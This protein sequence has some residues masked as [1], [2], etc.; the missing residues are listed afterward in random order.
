MAC[1]DLANFW[2]DDL[3][4]KMPRG[5]PGGGL[6][7][8]GTGPS[9]AGRGGQGLVSTLEPPS[10]RAGSTRSPT[11]CCGQRPHG[12]ASFNDTQFTRAEGFRP[13]AGGGRASR[14]AS[15]L[16]AA[17]WRRTPP[18]TPKGPPH[19]AQPDAVLRSQQAALEL[20]WADDLPE[21]TGEGKTASG[22]KFAG[23]T[24]PFSLVT[25]SS[26]RKFF[27]QFGALPALCILISGGS[28]Q[29]LSLCCRQS[30]CLSRPA[31]PPDTGHFDTPSP[32]FFVD[33]QLCETLARVV[34]KQ[35][36][37]FRFWGRTVR[38]ARAVRKVGCSPPP[39]VR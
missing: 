16:R 10:A 4:Q 25:K 26:P 24:S 35:L 11:L 36:E 13:T 19:Q 20:D 37:A 18:P 34:S 2:L 29:V 38:C 1:H 8:G 7:P 32:S 27:A 30:V 6:V 17:A 3:P 21:L 31:G 9:L 23:K 22:D 28:S 14:E 39:G 12:R 15:L 5:S 33:N